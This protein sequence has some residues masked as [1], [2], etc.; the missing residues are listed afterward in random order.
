MSDERRDSLAAASG[1]TPRLLAHAA[2]SGETASLLSSPILAE[3]G[4]QSA[5]SAGDLTTGAPDVRSSAGAAAPAVGS[6]IECAVPPITCDAASSSSMDTVTMGIRRSDSASCEPEARQS[7]QESELSRDSRA[8]RFGEDRSG[9]STLEEALLE[10]GRLGH[11]YS[12]DRL[13]ADGRLLVECRFCREEEYLD[14]LELGLVTASG[15]STGSTRSGSG[16][17][18]GD[19]G[20]GAGGGEGGGEGGGADTRGGVG[21]RGEG[22]AGAKAREKARGARMVKPCSCGGTMGRVHLR[23]LQQWIERRRMDGCDHDAL[24]CEV[25]RAPYH[26][27]IHER[28]DLTWERLCSYASISFY[29]EFCTICATL[30][31]MVFL[32][33]LIVVGDTDAEGRELSLFAA[34]VVAASVITLGILTLFK[35]TSRW[36]QAI[37]V[38]LLSPRSPLSPPMPSSPRISS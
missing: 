31:S 2:G 24:T 22:E 6:R 32:F 18:G 36:R 17:G 30:A 8:S 28:L 34:V 37:S 38:P 5:R 33:F 23:C 25:C 11:S 27:R 16:G 15:G 4:L 7:E 35:V 1:S 12:S 9:E 14:P 13:L 19:G 29:A 3:P 26:L 20:G 21:A 10:E